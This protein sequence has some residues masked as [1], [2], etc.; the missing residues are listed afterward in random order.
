LFI[1]PNADLIVT[2]VVRAR[3]LTREGRAMP[4]QIV[5]QYIWREEVVLEGRRFGRFAGERIAMLCGATLVIDENWNLIHWSRKP[6][7]TLLGTSKAAKAEQ[8]E[9]LRRRRE[10][11]ATIA[12]RI[13]AGEIG[14]AIGGEIGLV[15]RATP[16]FGVARVDGTLRFRLAPHFSIRNPAHDKTGERQW[17]ISF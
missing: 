12:A 13:D 14:E 16:P 10:L 5:V 8:A 6:G 1:P 3:K 15:E 2:E 7:T 17:Q 4:E 11:L 9:G